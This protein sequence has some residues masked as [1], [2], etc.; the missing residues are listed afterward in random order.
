MTGTITIAVPVTRKGQR[1]Y[2]QVNIKQHAISIIGIEAFVS[3]ITLPGGRKM[4]DGN[5]AG[6]VKLQAE[7]RADLSFIVQVWAGQS[8]V[9]PLLPGLTEV[10]DQLI[11]L[12]PS[13]YY[14]NLYNEKACNRPIDSYMLYGCYQ[15]ILGVQSNTDA[16]YTVTLCLHVQQQ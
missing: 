1:N 5:V 3:G 13:P 10:C 6:T 15:D 8:P 12:F 16:S 14:L 2:F 11:G 9:E 4:L 7:N